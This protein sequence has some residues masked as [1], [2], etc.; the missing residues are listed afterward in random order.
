M[1]LTPVLFFVCWLKAPDVS[2]YFRK[3][4]FVLSML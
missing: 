2:D 3:F 4:S 1:V